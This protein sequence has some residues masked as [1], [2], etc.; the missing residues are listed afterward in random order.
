L[1]ERKR[2]NQGAAG[3]GNNCFHHIYLLS[4]CLEFGNRFA[5]QKS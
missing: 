1:S 4:V 3:E 5:V 2:R